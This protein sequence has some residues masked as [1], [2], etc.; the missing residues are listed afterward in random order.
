MQVQLLQMQKQ[1]KLIKPGSS[2]LDLGC[3]PGAWLQVCACVWSFSNVSVVKFEDCLFNLFFGFHDLNWIQV[4][5]Q[6]L[7][8]LKTGGLVVGIDLKVILC[9]VPL[10]LLFWVGFVCWF[11]CICWG[12]IGLVGCGGFKNVGNVQ[13]RRWRSLLFT[14]MQEFKLFVQMSWTSRNTKFEH[15]LL[16][17][18]TVNQSLVS[19][20]NAGALECI[21]FQLH[22]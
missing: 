21:I 14:V 5:C 12:E 18:G 10:E 8:P 19:V 22:C 20:D 4:A 7:G 6:S 11:N 16:R 3:A 1:Y 13:S 2:V 17:Y 9:T 15:S